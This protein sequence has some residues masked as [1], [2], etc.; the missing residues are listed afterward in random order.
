MQA[1]GYMVEEEVAVA[2]VT[3]YEVTLF[4][5]RPADVTD[6]AIYISEPV[7]YDQARP[8]ARA[9]WLFFMQEAQ[10]RYPGTISSWYSQ[11]SGQC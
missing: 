8:S 3:N 4:M 10:R 9:S 6:K 5:Q 2:A 11:R 7:W 1:F